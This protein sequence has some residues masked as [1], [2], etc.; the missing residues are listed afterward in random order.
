MLTLTLFFVGLLAAF[1]WGALVV[2]ARPGVDPPFVLAHGLPL[3]VA[4]G[5]WGLAQVPAARS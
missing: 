4:L 3:L 5:G 2:D 1:W